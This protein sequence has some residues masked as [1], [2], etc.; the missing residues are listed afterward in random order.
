VLVDAAVAVV[1]VTGISIL[2]DSE[3][4]ASAADAGQNGWSFGSLST[5]SGGA[6]E[7][8]RAGTQKD[9]SEG[10]AACRAKRDQL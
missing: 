2:S 1:K 4:G 8:V 6:A 7:G 5:E 3:C 10:L 9:G